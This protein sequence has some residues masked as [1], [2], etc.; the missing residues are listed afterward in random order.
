MVCIPEITTFN[1]H[2]QGQPGDD[3]MFDLIVSNRA[4]GTDILEIE[5]TGTASGWGQIANEMKLKSN[6]SRDLELA[7]KIDEDA[8]YDDYDLTVIVTAIDGTVEELDLIVTVTDNPVNYEV[9]IELDPTNAETIAGK[10]VEFTVTIQNKGDE[11]DT[12]DLEA[13]EEWVTFDVNEITIGADGEA[14]VDGIISVPS[15]AS[16]G[17]SYIDISA[18]SRNDQTASDEKTIKVVVEELEYGATLRRDSGGLV[19]IAPGESGIFE[20]TLLSDSNGKQSLTI[21]TAAEAGN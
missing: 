21:T 6:E 13:S 15:D 16:N 2:K 18:T 19:T 5:M 12:F 17:N 3:V 8:E 14:T 9:E 10:D 4:S 1:D 11:Q 20:F 7:L